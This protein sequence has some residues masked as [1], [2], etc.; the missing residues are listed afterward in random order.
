LLLIVTLL[1]APLPV[2]FETLTGTTI[3]AHIFGSGA[4]IGVVPN[5]V[6]KLPGAIAPGFAGIVQVAPTLTSGATVTFISVSP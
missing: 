2:G 6:V 1:P 4:A 3:A 5:V